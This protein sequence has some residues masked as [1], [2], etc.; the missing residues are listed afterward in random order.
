MLE[1]HCCGER[2]FW[3]TCLSDLIYRSSCSVVVAS[4]WT[5]GEALSTAM[6]CLLP[7]LPYK[8]EFC[9]ARSLRL[10]YRV[11]HEPCCVIGDR[12]SLLISCVESDH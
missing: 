12:W 4:V 6:G 2:L 7:F 10:A 9:V 5:H 8:S 1:L 3:T 11:V